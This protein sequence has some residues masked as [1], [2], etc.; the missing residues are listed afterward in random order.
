MSCRVYPLRTSAGAVGEDVSEQ[1]QRGRILRTVRRPAYLLR[2]RKQGPG[3]P[4][5]YQCGRMLGTH[6][7][8]QPDVAHHPG[9]TGISPPQTPVARAY[10]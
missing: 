10:R 2:T 8:V 5:Q 1:I 4:E 9:G 3:K 6:K 7:G